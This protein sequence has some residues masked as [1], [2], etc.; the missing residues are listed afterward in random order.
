MCPHLDR[1]TGAGRPL[2]LPAVAPAGDPDRDKLCDD[3]LEPDE[4]ARI[5]FRFADLAVQDKRFA[6]VDINLL[7]AVLFLLPNDG[8]IRPKVLNWL[9]CED[10]PEYDRGVLG[11][12][13]RG[14]ARRCR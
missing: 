10:L 7:R 9:R 12:W 13:S 5:V 14:P 2:G 3:I 4:V 1:L 8:R 6:A 11:G